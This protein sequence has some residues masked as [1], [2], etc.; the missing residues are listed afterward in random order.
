MSNAKGLMRHHAD[1]EIALSPEAVMTKKTPEAKKTL[2][3]TEAKVLTEFNEAGDVHAVKIQASS[4][5][6]KRQQ[7]SDEKVVL[8]QGSAT[9]LQSAAQLHGGEQTEAAEV[10]EHAGEDEKEEKEEEEEE[11]D[12][13]VETEDPVYAETTN[14]GD[15]SAMV[16]MADIGHVMCKFCAKKFKPDFGWGLCITRGVARRD[17]F[18][19]PHSEPHT[20]SI[21]N[22][23]RRATE[24]GCFAPS[25]AKNQGT[26]S[27]RNTNRDDRLALQGKTV[28]N[29]EKFCGCMRVMLEGKHLDGTPALLSDG[30]DGKCTDA[31]CVKK[32]WCR[33]AGTCS[34]FKDALEC[35][36]SLAQS[37]EKRSDKVSSNTSESGLD[38]SMN[39]K[40]VE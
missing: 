8:W 29:P 24:T 39:D 37:L 23:R 27:G 31:D 18:D 3:R 35:P 7:K 5:L 12:E 21:D 16:P 26:G 14:G 33:C 22:S 40:C 20:V 25:Y 32:I 9:L 28:A 10:H 34:S 13:G 4:D 1:A 15:I 30:T 2:M 38:E 36:A 6:L 11:E 17:P 19:I